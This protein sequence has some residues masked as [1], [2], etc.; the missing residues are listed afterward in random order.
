MQPTTPIVSIIL[1][2][3]NGARFISEAITSVQN[4]TYN[5]WELLVI[6]DGSTDETKDVVMKYIQHDPRIRYIQ[7]E[8][9]LGIQ[10]TLNI[11]LHVS[12]GMFIARID[13]DDRWSMPD[14]LEKQVVFLQQHPEYVLV[15]TGIEIVNE[16][17]ATLYTHLFP[18]SD[19]AIRKNILSQNCFAHPSVVFNKEVVLKLGGYDETMHTR[20]IEDYELWLRLGTVGKFYNVGICATSLMQHTTSIS[21]RN[22]VAQYVKSIAITRQYKNAYPNFWYAYIKRLVVIDGYRVFMLL[23]SGIRYA[24]IRLNKK[25]L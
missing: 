7:N 20:H 25:Y 11:G 17:H 23:P 12:Q 19:L 3:R 14:K 10:K 8:T 9:N 6:D 4:Q 18:Q 22:K 24:L 15:G 13:D 16:Q 5:S 1:P 2:T 21:A